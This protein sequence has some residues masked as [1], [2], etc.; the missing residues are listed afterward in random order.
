MQSYDVSDK[1]HRHAWGYSGWF[2]KRGAAFARRVRTMLGRW[3][4]CGIIV[5]WDDLPMPPRKRG[6]PVHLTHIA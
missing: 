2:V 3:L 5:G 4:G 1:L 6:V